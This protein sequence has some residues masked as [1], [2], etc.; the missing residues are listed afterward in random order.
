MVLAQVMAHAFGLLQCKSL[1]TTSVQGDFYH[2]MQEALHHIAAA[3]F[4]DLWSECYSPPHIP[5]SLEIL[6]ILTGISRL[7]VE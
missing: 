4:C 6:E 7:Q 1:H 5:E 3:H 2:H